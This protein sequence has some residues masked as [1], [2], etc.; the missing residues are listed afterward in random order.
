MKHSYSSPDW[1]FYSSFYSIPVSTFFYSIS[2]P[3]I[4]FYSISLPVLCEETYKHDTFQ[5]LHCH[6]VTAPRS[7]TANWALRCQA[8]VH[9]PVYTGGKV[10]GITERTKIKTDSSLIFQFLYLFF[11]FYTVIVLDYFSVNSSRSRRR[12]QYSSVF[13]IFPFPFPSTGKTMLWSLAVGVKSLTHVN[14]RCALSCCW[15]WHTCESRWK[16][17]NSQAEIGLNSKIIW[18]SFDSCCLCDIVR[19]LPLDLLETFCL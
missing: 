11:R 12:N 3:V 2:V 14:K 15:S 8:A 10:I 6:C 16:P 19:V 18:N 1:F 13:H 7:M 9:E 4:F 5:S 17:L